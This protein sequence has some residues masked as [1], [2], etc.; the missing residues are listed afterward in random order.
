MTG[1]RTELL[2]V[3]ALLVVTAIWGSTFFLIKD[4]VTRVP[5]ADLLAVRFALASV[6]LAV[7]AGPRLRL[8]RRLLG[9]GAASVCSTAVAPDPADDRPGPHLGQQSR[10]S[11][12]VS[13]WWPP[14]CSPRW[15]SGSGS[16]AP[17]G[18]P[19]DW[20][21]VGLG[22]LSLRGFSI[23]YGELVTLVAAIVYAGH[24]VALGRVSTRRTRSA[25][26]W[27][28]WSRSPRSAPVAAAWPTASSPAGIQLPEQT[29]DWLIDDLPRR[30]SPGR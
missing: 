23:G 14:R 16:P 17:P 3:A 28:R 20:P 24:I 22:I 5:V 13:T 4:I 19:S 1:R 27:S 25:L 11:S 10:D 9:H 2:A 12:P 18:W 15:C 30:A 6:A 26:R 7:L 8:T 29:S 21:T